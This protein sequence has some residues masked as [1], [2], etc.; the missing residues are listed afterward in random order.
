MSK[1]IV[2]ILSVSV[3]S[4]LWVACQQLEEV[5]PIRL[6][7]FAGDYEAGEG[8][9]YVPLDENNNPIISERVNI[10]G[11]LIR[12]IPALGDTIRL[13]SP[14]LGVVRV[15]G[16]IRDQEVELTAWEN[17]YS[18]ALNPEDVEAYIA[19][20][21]EFFLGKETDGTPYI[22]SRSGGGIWSVRVGSNR[23]LIVLSKS[24][25]KATTTP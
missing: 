3:L 21:E 17:S 20:S 5:L 13:E 9:Y 11:E 15:K 23:Y 8:S 22:D 4:M 2:I 12:L 19:T 18:G 6:V 24:L 14:T 1:H 10:D 7:E 25:R 16:I